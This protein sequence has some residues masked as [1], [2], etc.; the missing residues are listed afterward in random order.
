L[1]EFLNEGYLV[2]AGAVLGYRIED[3]VKK[4]R[5]TVVSLPF[6][7]HQRALLPSQRSDI[8]NSK[9]LKL[10]IYLDFLISSFLLLVVTLAF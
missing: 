5:Y 4:S 10:T 8:I 7:I 3:L 9:F 2:A 6:L 1:R